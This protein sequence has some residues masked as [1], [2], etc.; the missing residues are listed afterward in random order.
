M[1]LLIMPV[2]IMM[3]AI[4]SH[5]GIISAAWPTIATADILREKY[6]KSTINPPITATTE[7]ESRYR[8]VARFPSRPNKTVIEV[9]LVAGPTNRKTKAAPGL[10]PFSINA[11]AMGVDAVAQSDWEGTGRS[12]TAPK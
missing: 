6:T 3:E 5:S 9:T 7:M 11:A 1:A 10:T 8:A 4:I 2:T 12:R